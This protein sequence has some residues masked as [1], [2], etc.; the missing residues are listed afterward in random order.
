MHHELRAQY[1][2]LL[3]DFDGVLRQWPDADVEIETRCGLPSGAIRRVAFENA[4]LDAVVTG[5]ISDEIWRDQIATALEQ[6][7][8]NASVREAMNE[9][10]QSSGVVDIEV[11]RL[12]E[13]ASPRLRIALATNATSRLRRDLES[14]QLGSLFDVIVNA[15]EI[16]VAK[17]AAAFYTRALQLCDEHAEN[18]LYVDDSNG[19]VES[20]SRLGI[21]S[22][23]FTG[24]DGLADFLRASGVL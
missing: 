7:Y 3:I 17:P 15:S 14:L 23:H 11:L 19:N 9:W 22:L 21:R 1:R 6:L 18:V 20:A 24:A 4:L 12:L 16:G 8:P 5:I 10:S 13:Q 2:L